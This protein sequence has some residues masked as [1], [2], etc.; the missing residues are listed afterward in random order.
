MHVHFLVTIG[1]LAPF[2]WTWASNN[3]TY[4]FYLAAGAPPRPSAVFAHA[5]II[6][7]AIALGLLVGAAVSWLAPRKP[8]RGWVV[9]WLSAIVGIALYGAALHGSPAWVIELFRSTGNLSFIAASA[10]FPTFT[11][12]RRAR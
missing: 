6:L 8:L 5:S 10:V 4:T 3:L 2:W 9:F 1:L 11:I 7:P 12:L